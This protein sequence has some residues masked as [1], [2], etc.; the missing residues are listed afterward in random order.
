MTYSQLDA[1]ANRIARA[2]AELGV[3]RGDRVGIWLEKTTWA[4]AAMQGTLRLGAAYVPLD[5]T[6]PALRVGRIIEDCQLR[7][8][9]TRAARAEEL[10]QSLSKTPR[11]L[12]VDSKPG[13]P[14]WDSLAAFSGEPLSSPGLTGSDL[15]YILYTSGSTGTPKG[16]C[17]SHQNALAFIEWAHA[18]LEVTPADRLSC[19]APFFFDLSVLDL[20]VTFL[21]GASVTLIPETLAFAPRRLVELLAHEG[22]T[23]W[24]SVPSALILMMQQGGLLEQR[25]LLLRAVLFAGEPFPIK[26]LRTLRRHLPVARFL[27]LYGPTETNVCTFHEVGEIPDERTLPVPIG[28]ACCGDRVWLAPLEDSAS[29]GLAG[30][31]PGGEVGELMVEGPTVMLGYWGHPPQGDRPY[32][33]GDICRRL[34][35]GGYQYLGRRDHMLKVRGHRIDPGEVETALLTHP[36]VREVAVIAEGVE[37]DRRLVAYV[38]SDAAPPPSLLELKQHCAEHLPRY[39]VIDRVHHVQS[40]PRTRNGK[41]DRRALPPSCPT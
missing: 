27:N 26:H 23:I 39:M 4:A 37:L 18:L 3:R 21:A 5:P 34:P 25:E 6:S 28:R 40:L 32:A 15:A 10:Q 7:A 38:V 22:I 29:E 9:V 30:D 1:S 14:A 24:Y 19:H 31:T 16:V 2:L 17:L 11:L 35:A 41:V 36:A 8:L 33:T 13:R 12:R 20:Y